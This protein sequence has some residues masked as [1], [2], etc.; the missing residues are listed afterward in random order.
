MITSLLLMLAAA[1]SAEP[2]A[3]PES[4]K[5][6]LICRYDAPTSLFM[7]RRK[8]CLTAEEW[9]KRTKDGH[10]ASRTMLNDYLGDTNCLGNGICTNF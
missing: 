7:A 6:K 2:A 1:Q 9:E 8:M 4:S 3:A 10:E 5:V